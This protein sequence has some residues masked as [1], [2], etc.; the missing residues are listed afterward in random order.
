[1]GYDLLT[2]RSDLGALAVS[3]VEIRSNGTLHVLIWRSKADPT[4]YARV[5]FTSKRTGQ[6]VT[7][8]LAWRTHDFE[9]LFCPIYQGHDLNRYSSGTTVTL[10]KSAAKNAGLDSDELK[11]FSGH[12]MGVGA[13]QDLLGA[14]HNTAAIM[15]AG[16][17]KPI[18]VPTRYLESAEC[19]VW[20]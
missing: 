19:N 15:R 13:A 14:G 6:L 18:N 11:D 20:L 7:D 2:R 16:G 1:M 9:P 5:A 4:S 8:W 3:D 17:W 12:S 10:I